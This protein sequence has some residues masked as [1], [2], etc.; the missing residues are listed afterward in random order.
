MLVVALN[1]LFASGIN[2]SAIVAVCAL[3]ANVRCNYIY[4]GND[5]NDENSSNTR[6][7]G[8]VFQVFA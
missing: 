8:Y 4:L 5:L 2:F 6:A 3:S 7:E 1:V